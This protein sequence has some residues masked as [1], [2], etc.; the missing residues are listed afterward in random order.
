ME[1]TRLTVASYEV[2]DPGKVLHA[3]LRRREN[4][5]PVLA[6]EEKRTRP[7]QALMTRSCWLWLSLVALRL[8]GASAVPSIHMHPQLQPVSEGAVPHRTVLYRHTV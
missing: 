7:T 4:E 5:I 1:T 2:P 6:E 3:E 8:P